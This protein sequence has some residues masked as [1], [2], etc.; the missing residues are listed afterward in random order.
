MSLRSLSSKLMISFKNEARQKQSSNEENVEAYL[1]FLH[2]IFW[3]SS[4]PIVATPKPV[5]QPQVEHHNFLLFIIITTTLT[6]IAKQ[7]RSDHIL[8]CDIELWT[9]NCDNSVLVISGLCCTFWI[10]WEAGNRDYFVRV[11]QGKQFRFRFRFRYPYLLHYLLH[12][13]FHPRNMGLP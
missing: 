7:A 10:I 5:R 13:V 8:S 4:R 3:L 6:W 11:L 12:L 2:A 9:V 1:T